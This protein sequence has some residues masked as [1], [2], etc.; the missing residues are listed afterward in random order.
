MNMIRKNGSGSGL[1]QSLQL[2]LIVLVLAAVMT[3]WKPGI[4]L[5]GSNLQS[6]LLSVCI[7]GIMMCGTIFPLLN[8]GIDLSIGS[9]AALAG[10]VA[11]LLTVRGGETSSAAVLGILAG[12]A[13]GALCGTVNGVVSSLFGIPAFVVTLASSNIVLGLAQT[14]SRQRTITCLHSDLIRW[15]GTGKL[16]GIP[17]P[18]IFFALLLVL[19]WWMLKYTRFGR[20]AYAAGG[21]P[22][23]THYSGVNTRMIQTV[24]YLISGTT[25]AMAGIVLSCFNRQAVYTQASGYDGDVLVALVVGGVSMAGGEGKITGAIFGLLILGILNNAMILIGI[26]AIYQRLVKGLLVIVAVAIDVYTRNKDSG[27]KRKTLAS[28]FVGR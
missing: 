25:A 3:I 20:Y 10:C 24:T 14:V 19:T 8:G 27:M 26:D 11:I 16:L 13:V 2:P 28:I 4:F 15:I 18:I 12:M 7:Y 6:I 17:F 5:T 22:T 23:A 21:N 1:R 9:T